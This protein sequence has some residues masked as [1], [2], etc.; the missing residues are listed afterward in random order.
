MNKKICEICNENHVTVNYKRNDKVYY[1][2]KCYNCI[3]KEK[4]SNTKV[5][6]LLKKSGYVKKLKCDRCGFQCKTSKQTEIYYVD[7]NSHNVNLN[8]LRTQCLNCNAEITSNP[9]KYKNIIAD[10]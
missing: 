7:G 9:A 2:K 10:F 6:Q 5:K 3:K 4:E 8:N 1:R